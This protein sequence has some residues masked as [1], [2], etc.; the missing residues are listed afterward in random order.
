M[1]GG[2]LFMVL[3]AVGLLVESKVIGGGFFESHWGYHSVDVPVNALLAAGVLGLYL[4]QIG[5]FGKIGK[6]GF[7][8]A[9]GG[10]ALTTLGGLAI[11]LLEMGIGE[12]ATPGWLDGVTHMLAMLLFVL[13]SIVFGVATFGAGVLPRVGGL[14]LV[15]GPLSFLGL[16]FGGVEGWLLMAPALLF[17]SGWAWLGYALISEAGRSSERATRA[18]AQGEANDAIS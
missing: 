10:F 2:A 16:L 18:G 12:G 4:R 7:Y 11:I 15:V 8:M 5:N 6:T 17:G 3:F 13:G 14:L 9:F 1:L